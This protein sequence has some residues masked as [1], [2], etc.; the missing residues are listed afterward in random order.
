MHHFGVSI[1]IYSILCFVKCLNV[2]WNWAERV[3]LFPCLM[4]SKQS[5]ILRI[6]GCHGQF[7]GLRTTAY[8]ENIFQ[9]WKSTSDHRSKISKKELIF[10]WKAK[11]TIIQTFNS[12]FGTLVSGILWD[13]FVSRLWALQRTLTE[14]F[15]SLFYLSLRLQ[16]DNLKCQNSKLFICKNILRQIILFSVERFRSPDRE[17]RLS[18]VLTKTSASH[19]KLF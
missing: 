7:N 8:R 16:E 6:N 12:A 10:S 2:D 17:E 5:I 4:Q 19:F 13:V 18:S 14:M 15:S 11:S 9:F 3:M 1:P